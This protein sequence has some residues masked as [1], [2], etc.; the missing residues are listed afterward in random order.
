MSRTSHLSH[1]L[2][3]E[4]VDRFQ[5]VQH[6]LLILERN[7][8]TRRVT[9][10]K[11]GISSSESLNPSA[12]GAVRNAFG[13]TYIC[14]I[15]MGFCA[16]FSQFHSLEHVETQF[17]SFWIFSGP[18]YEIFNY[19]KQSDGCWRQHSMVHGN[20]VGFK[21]SLDASFYC[22]ASIVYQWQGRGHHLMNSPRINMNSLLIK[23]VIHENTHI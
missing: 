11:A 14:Q 20:R 15:S 21:V 4:H 23:I 8:R 22:A 3:H 5:H 19:T 18:F 13:S 2:C 9:I 12:N 1:R 6:S 7:W 17:I 16:I 10:F